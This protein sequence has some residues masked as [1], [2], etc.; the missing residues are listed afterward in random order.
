MCWCRLP[1]SAY[2]LPCTKRTTSSS[3]LR[4]PR[5]RA[6]AMHAS[7]RA[8]CRLLPLQPYQYLDT[9]VITS[10]ENLVLLSGEELTQREW[11]VNQVGQ[12]RRE[13]IYFILVAY[14]DG[15]VSSSIG[16]DHAHMCRNT[17]S[18]RTE[19]GSLQRG[20]TMPS[21]HPPSLPRTD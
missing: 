17:N 1:S 21:A 16:L 9:S 8:A 12:A 6:S 20:T 13:I 5:T 4:F 2:F 7:V 19:S 18:T 3:G 11:D 15:P 10:F 14:R